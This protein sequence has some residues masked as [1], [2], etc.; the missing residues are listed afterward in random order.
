MKISVITCVY[1]RVATIADAIDSVSA[2]TYGEVEHIIVDAQSDDGTL[3]VIRARQHDRL[4]LESGPD[5]GIY[6]AL[7]KGCARATGDIVGVV[8]SDDWLADERVLAWVAAAFAEGAD[9]VY[10]DLDY[11]SAR[12]PSRVI[13]AWKTGAF[14]LARLKWG[15]MPPHPALFVRRE[16][17]AELGFYNTTYRIAADYDL[18]LRLFSRTSLRA[19]YIPR[20]LVKMRTG[21]ASNGSLRQVLRKSAEDYR[22]LRANR[23]GGAATLLAKNLR[24]VGQLLPGGP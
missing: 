22:A 8:H 19:A 7:N 17:L 20:V 6:D 1:N 18:V 12:D 9:V 16:L 3:D 15:W 23:I 4:H 5:A 13:R 24:K 21:G 11:V 10:G 14:N 2:Q